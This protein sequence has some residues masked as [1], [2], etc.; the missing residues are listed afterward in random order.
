M[1]LNKRQVA[2]TP[3]KKSV[4]RDEYTPEKASVAK[5]K[6]ARPARSDDENPNN[7][8]NKETKSK[9]QVL[10]KWN[11]FKKQKDELEKRI[12][13]MKERRAHNKK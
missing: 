4:V 1:L 10:A 11:T 7:E 2:K 5:K 6:P 8:N 12:L 9:R 3:K 13:R